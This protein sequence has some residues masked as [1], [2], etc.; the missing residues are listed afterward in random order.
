MSSAIEGLKPELV[1][2]YFAGLSKIPRGSK[3]EAAAGAWVLK[4]AKQLG[5]EARQDRWGNVVARKPASPGRERTP[6]VCLQGHLDMVC[7]KRPDLKHDFLKDPLNLVRDGEWLRADGTTLGAD[8]G[9]AVA[10]ALA[11]MEDRSL[12]H[13]PLEFLFTVDEETGL[14]G[15]KGLEPG[16]VTSRILLNLDSEEE[17]A[18]FVGCSGGRDTNGN[19]A[20]EWDAAPAGSVALEITVGGLRGGHS[21]LEIDKGRGNAIKILGRAL[22]L[23]GESGARLARMDGGNKRN[24]IPR[25]AVALVWVPKA[26]LAGATAAL[27]E[28]DRVA[29]AELATVEPGLRVTA[30]AVKTRGGKVFRRPLQKKLLQVIS[31][32]PHGVIK[33]SAEI[34]WLVETSTNV[35]VIATGKKS[36]S[37]ATSQRSSVASEIQEIGDTVVAVLELGGAEVHV[38]DGYPGW[39]PNLDS[40]ILKTAA[41][42]YRRLR[43]SEPDVKAVHAGL[44]CGIIG[45]RYPGMDMVSFGP[46]LESVHSPEERIHVGSVG[47]FYEFLLA[48]LK[49]VK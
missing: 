11:I 14:T 23:A 15:A 8:N 17:T 48:I 13:G 16:F 30:T 37:L 2:K 32:L 36:V 44:E 6:S 22:R 4:V 49:D 42:T 28:F 5:L 41:G 35:A 25:D 27:E 3:N 9:I 19:W 26:K 10:S 43:G 29:R 39:K 18:L 20:L 33:M 7:E 12:E 24:A 40:P 21:G 47:R 34:S 46:V 45:E 1:W 31:G 38:S